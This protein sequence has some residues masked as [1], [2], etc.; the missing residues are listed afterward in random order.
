[1]FILCVRS[2][3]CIFYNTPRNSTLISW[4]NEFA[5]DDTSFKATCCKKLGKQ[6]ARRPIEVARP[7]QGRRRYG[8][9]IHIHLWCPASHLPVCQ[10]FTACTQSCM[11]TN[12]TGGMT[13]L[14][15]SRR[16]DLYVR[17]KNTSHLTTNTTMQHHIAAETDTAIEFV[18]WY[19]NGSKT[20]RITYLLP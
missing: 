5:F 14:W 9:Y 17:H 8:N 15:L 16:R 19:N 2:C 6:R 10:S 18:L 12:T 4:L 13:L 11:V 1:M 20:V 7:S 3:V